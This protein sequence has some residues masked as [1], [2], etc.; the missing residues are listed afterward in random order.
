MATVLSAPSATT[1][2]AAAEPAERIRVLLVDDDVDH[3]MIVRRTLEKQ[4]GFA[5][6][7][8]VDGASCLETV[9]KEAFGVVLLDYSLPKMN[10]LEVLAKIR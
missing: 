1:T 7:H 9:A 6:T 10:G 3:A 5:V 4:G 8:V 2:P